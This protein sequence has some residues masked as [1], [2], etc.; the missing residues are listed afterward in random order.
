V[1]LG[2]GWSKPAST[3]LLVPVGLTVTALLPCVSVTNPKMFAASTVRRS[4]FVAVAVKVTQTVLALFG[5]YW[6]E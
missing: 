1:P 6:H 3:V 5:T 2:I 4:A